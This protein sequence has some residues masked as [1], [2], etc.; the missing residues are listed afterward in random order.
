MSEQP[1][2]GDVHVMPALPEEHPFAHQA[3]NCWCNPYLDSVAEN[4]VA[5]W[6]HREH[7]D[8]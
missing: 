1:Q 2:E 5:V 6:V 3:I 8:A 4:G 7:A